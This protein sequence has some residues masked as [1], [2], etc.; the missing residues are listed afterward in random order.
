ML[1]LY[2]HKKM[3]LLVYICYVNAI[4]AARITFLGLI[5]SMLFLKLASCE[6]KSFTVNVCLWPHLALVYYH[7]CQNLYVHPTKYQQSVINKG[8]VSYMLCISAVIILDTS[9]LTYLLSK[10]YLPLWSMSST[11][12]VMLNSMRTKGKSRLIP[13]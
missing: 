5:I 10:L 11:S 6:P 2:T 1:Y 12:A 9:F 13:S 8:Y 4:F 7:L 3:L